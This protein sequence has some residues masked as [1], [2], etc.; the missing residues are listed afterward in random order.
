MTVNCGF[1]DEDQFDR[2][3]VSFFSSLLSDEKM[4][5]QP[6]REEVS[7]VPPVLMQV[8]EDATQFHF[9]INQRAE[10]RRSAGRYEGRRWRSGAPVC[11]FNMRGGVG[12]GLVPEPESTNRHP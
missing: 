3:G 7:Q 5:E 8:S 11:L 10:S 2:E 4:L 12:P 6:I 9:A 1:D